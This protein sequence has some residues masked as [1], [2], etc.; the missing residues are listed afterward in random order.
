MTQIQMQKRAKCRASK[1]ERKSE[2]ARKLVKNI[3]LIPFS[4]NKCET[5]SP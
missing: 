5:Q 4:G 3:I 2:L 1:Q